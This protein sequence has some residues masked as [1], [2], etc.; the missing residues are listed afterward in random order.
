MLFNCQ[1]NILRYLPNSMNF[2]W[3]LLILV[4]SIVI[5]TRSSSTLKY[6]IKYIGF[7][8]AFIFST[9]LCAVFS[10]FNPGSSKNIF[11]PQFCVRL[12]HMEWL[13]GL[14]IQIDDWENL[15]NAEKPVVIVSN[16][17]TMI[18]ILVLLKIIPN[19]TTALAK[20]SL[21]YVPIM[22][23]VCWLYGVFFIDRSKHK[24]AIEMMH[25]IGLRMKKH[26]TNVCVFS[27]GT[28]TQLDKVGEFKKGAFH[29]AIQ[30]QTP[31]VPIIIGN[32]RNVI[33]RKNHLFEGGTIRVKA[34]PAIKT[35]GLQTEDVNDLTKKVQNL[36]SSAFN[37]DFNNHIDAYKD[38]IPLKEN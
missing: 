26:K 29:L 16:H 18:D 19:N 6:H 21:F 35:E 9:A 33:D 15:K 14:D 10:I 11:I 31:I 7:G 24:S 13:F 3:V 22:G 2:Y 8:L 38:L 1:V 27:E 36:I 32:Y 28:R 20:K 25:N 4:I 30:G 34:L 23:L 17:Q 5:L 37:E 12:I